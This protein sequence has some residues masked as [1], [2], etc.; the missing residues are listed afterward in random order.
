MDIKQ[1]GPFLG[2]MHEMVRI[3]SAGKQAPNLSHPCP[4]IDG[5]IVECI[6]RCSADRTTASSAASIG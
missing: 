3:I 2:G 5:T 1:A 6:W 4:V